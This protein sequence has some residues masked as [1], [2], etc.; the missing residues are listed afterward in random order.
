MKY[1][2]VVEGRPFEIEIRDDASVWVDGMRREVD[3]H[4][5]DGQPFH[6]LLI[7]GQSFETQVRARVGGELEVVV[8]GRTHRTQLS[9]STT[10]LAGVAAKAGQE[11]SHASGAQAWVKAP[12]PGLLVETRVS[13]GEQ[14]LEGDVVVVLE[15][16]KMHLEL[17]APRAGI[18]ESLHASPGQE[19][20][21]DEVLAIIV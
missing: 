16:M 5:A 9:M 14:V 17:R 4:E 1:H 11:H 2:V 3:L 19:V 21:L 7:D 6:S 8:K 10:Q 15:S 12:L 13:K 20:D 18:V